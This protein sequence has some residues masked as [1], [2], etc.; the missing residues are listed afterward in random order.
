MS[1]HNKWSTIKHK[2]A[3]T[4]AV[5]GKA[6]TKVAREIFAAVKEGGADPEGNSRLRLAIEN[7]KK[8]NMP[9]DNIK[10]A[11]QRGNKEGANLEDVIYEGYAPCGVAV[12][13]IT[14]TDNRNRTVTEIRSAFNKNGGSMGDSGCVSWMFQKRG[15][16]TINDGKTTE[17]K[18][19]DF[20]IDA[21]AEDI[22]SQSDGSIEIRT[23]V[24]SFEAVRKAI[25][26]NKIEIEDSE[27]AYL[28]TTTLAINDLESATKVLKTIEK[29][30]EID[31]VQDVYAN[32]EIP[33]E[34]LEKVAE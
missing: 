25:E 3:K 13:I 30:E 5:K 19:F 8:V 12:L 17:D 23:S 15:L 16:I 7:A 24:E 26:T 31:D 28:P 9:K 4:D 10:N 32:F 11:I 29:L 1:G 14:M 6:F 2:K 27:I 18:I 20:V 22:I 21:G 34:I 33:D